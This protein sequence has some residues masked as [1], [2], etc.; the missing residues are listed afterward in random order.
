MET[1][2]V[3]LAL[4]AGNSL[5]TSE[6]PEQ[7]PVTQNFDVFFDLR[8][9]KQLSKQSRGWWFERPSGFG[10]DIAVMD[11]ISVISGMKSSKIF[12][13]YIKYIGAILTT[14]LFLIL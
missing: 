14:L 11:W 9:N 13:S 6:F 4:C 8:L 5:V 1:F 7:K 10:D 3:L 12:Y 2:S